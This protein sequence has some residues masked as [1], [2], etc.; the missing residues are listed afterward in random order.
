MIEKNKKC[1]ILWL[2]G[3]DFTR[4]P[5]MTKNVDTDCMG[6]NC[7]WWREDECYIVKK[8]GETNK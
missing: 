6:E 2:S 7:A 8:L 4:I 3:D 1:P 5:H